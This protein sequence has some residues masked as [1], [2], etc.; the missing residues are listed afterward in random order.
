MLHRILTIGLTILALSTTIAVGAGQ[1]KGVQNL[2]D[3]APV[4]LQESVRLD[5][6]IVYLGDLFMNIGDKAKIAVAYTPEPGKR[7]IFDAN[8]LSR[9]ARTHRLKWRPMSRYDRVVIERSSIVISREQIAEE[10]LQALIDQGAEADMEVEFSN[11]M[12]RMHVGGDALAVVGVE[13]SIL[14]ARTNRFSAIIHAPAGDPGAKRIRIT[15]RLHRTSEVPV[16]ARRILSSEILQKE[17][18]KWIKVRSRRLQNDVILSDL[19]LIGKSPRR[20]LRAGQPIRT[21]AVRRP[22][23]IKKGSLVTII[24]TS[25][26]MT[27][28][29]KGKANS[30]GSEGDLIQVTN[31][32][33]KTIIEAEVIGAGRVAVRPAAQLAMNQQ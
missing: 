14:D 4:T 11:R 16:P 32:Q 31:I 25:S 6:K 30:A 18:I 29:S 28:T 1:E 7:T 5:G 27:L 24:L 9:I 23:L 19:D 26:K 13:D 22:V 2:G 8:W 33:S 3:Q 21:S 17:D 15:G 12:L 20:G 10:V